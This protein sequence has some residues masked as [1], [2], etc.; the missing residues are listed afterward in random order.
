MSDVDLGARVVRIDRYWLHP[1]ALGLFV[2][3]LAASC[4]LSGAIT[5][6]LAP[7]VYA[8]PLVFMWWTATRTRTVDARVTV[9]GLVLGGVR[10]VPRGA[11]S[12]G[13]VSPDGDGL[14][15]AL[16]LRDRT[17]LRVSARDA[18]DARGLLTA[19][20][21]DPSQ[22]RTEFRH[23]RAF[24]QILTVLLG[25]LLGVFA[26]ATVMSVL[27]GYGVRVEPAVALCV[28]GLCLTALTVGLQRL[29]F[30]R[31]DVTIGREGMRVGGRL[32]ARYIPWSEVASVVEG[33]DA[34]LLTGHDG[35]VR[36]VWCNPDEP[37]VRGAVVERVREALAAYGEAA[38]RV[39]PLAVLARDGRS[40][41]AW[42]E[43][44]RGLVDAMGDYRQA[45]L[46]RARLEAVLADPAT[47][48][49]FRIAAALALSSS[50]EGRS[51]V[52]VAAEV[53]AEPAEREALARIAEG[54]TDDE[55]VE[56]ALRRAR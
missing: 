42:R 56:A 52:R 47:S 29:I 15:V 53:G 54:A 55:A 37:W 44:L 1:A 49:E 46:D 41:A 14:V 13:F 38:P 25:P 21:Q 16:T 7:L 18:A 10:T 27:R 50:D 19:L 28:G 26:A 3:A 17:L 48:A 5:P 36:R 11:I 12:A 33:D 9:E 4:A 51:R 6:M 31:V 30:P 8:T 43:S 45:S 40:V 39:D 20:G 35:R 24:H 34:V 23:R 32:G 22:R 2:L